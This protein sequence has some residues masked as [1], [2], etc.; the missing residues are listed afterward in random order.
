[1]SSIGQGPAQTDQANASGHIANQP[2]DY[3]DK[4]VRRGYSDQNSY[5]RVET[6]EAARSQVPKPRLD[7]PA[8]ESL[9][10]AAR[11]EVLRDFQKSREKP[12]SGFLRQEGKEQLKQG[13]EDGVR[14]AEKQIAELDTG[15]KAKTGDVV[16]SGGKGKTSQQAGSSSIS[17]SGSNPSTIST[18]TDKASATTVA[19]AAAAKGATATQA[20]NPDLPTVGEW[21]T[22][23]EVFEDIYVKAGSI[24]EAPPG[25]RE[26]I[27]AEFAKFTQQA[28]SGRQAL[29]VNGATTMLM[30]IQSKLQ[31]N[32][33]R[34]DQETIKIKQVEYNQQF[35]ESIGKIRDSIAEAKKAKTS[36]LISKIFGWIA[37]IV[38]VV[39]TVIVAALGAVFTGGVAT[40]VAVTLM[41]AA[42]AVVLTMQVSTEAGST[43]MM[44]MFGDSK[45]AKIAAMVF[46]TALIVALSVGGA[47]AGGFAGAGAGAGGAAASGAANTASTGASAGATATATAA[48]TAATASSLTAKVTSALNTITKILQ[49]V[50]GAAMIGDG[51][52]QIATSVYNYNADM[53]RAEAM[54]NRAFMLRL[55]QA[56]DDA[57]EAIAQAID[58][59]QAGYQVAASIIKAD[60]E[61]KTNLLSKLKA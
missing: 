12:T 55:Q 30:A 7:S 49:V 19:N 5:S 60:H 6:E 13:L 47:V 23:A 59:L 35:K 3:S 1:M 42:L 45:E 8:P 14:N 38:M 4:S 46:W 26:E 33:I 50:S 37:V 10:D 53:A 32:R 61:T 9:S 29:D 40:G 15:G 2:V 52:S 48:N 41:I 17:E 39:V 20:A 16:D 24:K 36:G 58:E 57:T 43:W 25:L 22:F 27:Q 11:Q 56:V 31:D 51:S 28:L 44:D 18:N 54:E 34:F 21:D